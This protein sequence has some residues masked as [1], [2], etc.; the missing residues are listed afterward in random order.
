[1]RDTAPKPARTA[2][3]RTFFNDFCFILFILLF[4]RIHISDQIRHLAGTELRPANSLARHLI[5]HG[6]PVAPERGNDCDAADRAGIGREVRRAAP[7]NSMALD[8]VPGY[9]NA[10]TARRV[11]RILKELRRPNV[12]ENRAHFT[13]IESRPRGLE[14]IGMV[15]EGSGYVIQSHSL[16][17]ELVDGMT[18]GTALVVEQ[19]P[20]FVSGG[21]GESPQGGGGGPRRGWGG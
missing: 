2:S 15:P 8:A 1:A 13:L 21:D 17:L 16:S 14:P 12:T 9:E 5:E 4:S 20:A 18:S 10:G 3:D 7:H 19:F 6:G 11:A